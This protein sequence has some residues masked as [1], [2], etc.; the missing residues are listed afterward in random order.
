MLKK[1][2]YIFSLLGL[3]SSLFVGGIKIVNASDPIIYTC[4]MV[5][6]IEKH[7]PLTNSNDAHINLKSQGLEF[8]SINYRTVPSEYTYS[9]IRFKSF[10]YYFFG[11]KTRLECEYETLDLKP[12]TLLAQINKSCA[13]AKVAAGELCTSLKECILVCH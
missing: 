1:F 13:I 10:K 3:A 7:F 4:P 6:E 12:F 8:S 9:K 11:T 5:D 2:L